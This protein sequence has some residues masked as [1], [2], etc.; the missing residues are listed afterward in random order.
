MAQSGSDQSQANSANSANSSQNNTNNALTQPEQSPR[1]QGEVDDSGNYDIPGPPPVTRVWDNKIWRIEVRQHPLRARM[2]GFGD[3]DR[4]PISP[5]PCVQL[6][7]FDATTQQEIDY[8]QVADLTKL[9]LMVDL[10]NLHGSREDNCV[11]HTTSSPSISSTSISNYPHVFTGRDPAN[12]AH[13]YIPSNMAATYGAQ[14]FTSPTTSAPNSAASHYP[15]NGHNAYANGG[16]GISDAASYGA[17]PFTSP[18]TS[19][20]NSA[21]SY[22]PTNGHHAYANGV[23]GSV[24]DASYG[25]QTFTSPTTSTPNSAASYYPTN[26]HHAYANGAPNYTQRNSQDMGIPSNGSVR[27][28][29]ETTIA[30]NLI[31]SSSAG[32]NLLQDE[33]G[34]VGIWFVLQ[35]ISVRT[36]GWFRLKMNLFN[37]AQLSFLEEGNRAPL[38]SGGELLNEAPCLASA[39]S[40]PFKVYSAKKFPGVI[41]STD[42]SKTF[43][44]QGVKIPV[45]KD[46]GAPKKR[47][48][49]SNGEISITSA[50][51]TK[52]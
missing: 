40:R 49:D 7:V 19:A 50:P 15:T 12:L 29:R 17:Q 11:K 42:L 23:P 32:A 27:D 16:P 6:R 13:D 46:H 26:G 14:P 41:E 31:G 33:F 18:T 5:P 38:A 45:R 44:T 30:R 20:P 35:D 37:L 9:V 43:A 34:E 25:A 51:E 21:A 4:R 47:K 24:R 3:K 2:C 22:Y 1:V 8:T 52:E 36:E 10:W 39:F 48:A 28:A